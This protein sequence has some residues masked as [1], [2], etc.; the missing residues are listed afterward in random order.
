MSHPSMIVN[1]ESLFL[2]W[3]LPVCQQRLGDFHRLYVPCPCQ[4]TD[5]FVQVLYQL[6]LLYKPLDLPDD[7]SKIIGGV[8]KV[9]T[10]I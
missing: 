1:L 4:R 3:Y 8:Y 9:F 2:A 7:P 10:T 5:V 6:K